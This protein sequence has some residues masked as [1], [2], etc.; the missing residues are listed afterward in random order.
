MSVRERLLTLRRHPANPVIRP[1]PDSYFSRAVYN[2]AAWRDGNRWYLLARCEATGDPCSG[3]LGLAT[4]VD[5]VHFTLAPEPI[6]VPEHAYERLGCEDPRVTR[7]PEGWVLTY[8]GK[9]AGYP[10][11]HLCLAL[12]HDGRGWEKQGVVLAPGP[13]TW[14]E[15]QVKAGAISPVRWRGQYVMFFMGE[16]RPWHTAIGLATSRDLRTWTPLPEPVLRPRPGH[17]DSMGVEP[18]PPPVLTDAGLLFIYNGWN[19]RRVHCVGV[20]W[21]DPEDPR[22]VLARA[23]APVLRPTTHWERAGNVPNVVFATGLVI[24]P[25]IGWLYY[26]AADRCVGL[27]CLRLDGQPLTEPVS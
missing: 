21:L 2:P 9:T 13:G 8:V 26:G 15:G 7:L 14:Y 22:R 24:E 10:G 12:S 19:A 3:R 1:G 6:L 11:H 23:Q 5:G 20:A 4:G 27:A 18:G 17:F 25:P 16:R